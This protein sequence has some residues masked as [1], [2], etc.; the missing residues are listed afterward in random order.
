MIYPESNLSQIMTIQG[1]DFGNTTLYFVN[2]GTIVPF[3]GVLHTVTQVQGYDLIFELLMIIMVLQA[4]STLLLMLMVWK[5]W[6]V[7]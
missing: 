4:V 7:R 1:M 2:N 3:H 6:F 5:L